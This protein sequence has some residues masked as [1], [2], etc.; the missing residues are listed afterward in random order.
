MSHVPTQNLRNHQRFVPIFHFIAGPILFINAAYSVYLLVRLADLYNWIHLL[1]AIALVLLFLSV[2]RFATV[3]QD[4]I[5]RLEEQ[6]RF[7][8]LLPAALRDRI[9]EFT[10]DQFVALR[11]ASDHELPALAQQVLDQRI[12][13]RDAIKEMVRDWRP[14]FAR[15]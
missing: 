13:D 9:H 15:V 12:L 2:R 6:V 4:R 10:I 8:R 1:V 11:F 3:L 7:E 5:I 14:D